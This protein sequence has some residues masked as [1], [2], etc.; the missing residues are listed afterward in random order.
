M[1]DRLLSLFCLKELEQN[2]NGLTTDEMIARTGNAGFEPIN[3]KTFQRE[4][5]IYKRYG[6]K[7]LNSRRRHILNLDDDSLKGFMKFLQD[8]SKSREY[9]HI[10]YGDIDSMRGLMYFSGQHP[11]IAHFYNIITAIIEDR[12]LDFTYTPQSDLTRL[13]MLQRSKYE[14]T[15]PRVIPVHM[16]PHYIVTGGN[17]F[18]VLGEYFEKK[19]FYKSLFKA[20]VQRHYEMRGIAGLKPGEKGEKQL[21][22]DVQD[23]YRNSIHIW[24]GGR[25]YEVVLEEFWYDGGKPRRKKR[26]VNGED[27][28]L[29][30]AAGSLGRIRIVNPPEEL[31]NRAKQIGLP[32][33]LVFR[34][35]G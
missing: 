14:A 22:I 29:S 8:F 35:D 19:G 30:L 27:E 15:N 28:V 13:R 11:V 1:N 18:L 4:L 24:A 20:P 33:D 12:Y 34:F 26:T 5:K 32:E 31:R 2:Q 7:I 17:S 6:I 16:L 23:T 10:F 21:A 25:E 3:P 9:A